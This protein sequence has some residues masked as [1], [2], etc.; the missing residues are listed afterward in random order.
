MHRI[1]FIASNTING[2]CYDLRLL[3]TSVPNVGQILKHGLNRSVKA[4]L[5]PAVLNS[6]LLYSE[7]GRGVSGLM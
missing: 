5:V 1:Y 7:F 3:A 6:G 4:P 2:K